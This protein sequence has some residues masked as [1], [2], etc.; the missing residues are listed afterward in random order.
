[1]V[2]RPNDAATASI[3]GEAAA[4]FAGRSKLPFKAGADL[5]ERRRQLF[6]GSANAA[7]L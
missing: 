4:R 7:R 1:M 6:Q 3:V 5:G 2:A